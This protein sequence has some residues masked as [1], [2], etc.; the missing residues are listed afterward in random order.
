MVFLNMFLLDARKRSEVNK[1]ET[2][3]KYLIKNVSCECPKLLA[4]KWQ[5]E[6]TDPVSKQCTPVGNTPPHRNY[7]ANKV[8]VNLND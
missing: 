5:N 2:A 7:D 8:N 4:H 3:F 1:E 6:T